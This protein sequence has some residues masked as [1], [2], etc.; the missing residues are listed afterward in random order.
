MKF[1]YQQPSHVFGG[2]NSFAGLKKTAFMC[3][4]EG[5]DSFWIMD[6]LVQIELA[7]RRNDP[8]LESYTATAALASVTSKIRLGVLCSC[9]YFRNPALVAKMGATIDQI[10]SGRFWLG[11]GAGWYGKE[12]RMYGFEFP[13]IR[14]RLQML[15]ESLQIIKGAWSNERTFSF[16]GKYYS[17]K[18]II[19]EPPPIQKP[20]P[21]ILV[22]GGGEKRTLKLVAKYADACNLFPKGGDLE[23]KLSV[24]R[25]HCRSVGR[26]YSSILKTKLSS[27]M[28]GSNEKDAQRKIA[29]YKPQSIS[30]DSYL[31]SALLGNS[32]EI[33]KEIED[34][35]RMGIEYLII[36]F[37]G[38][39]DPS[40][41]K[42]F[43]KEIMSS[44]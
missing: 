6:H 19:V 9:N 27:V 15:E 20:H 34:Y 21:P 3:E 11:L 26:D 44:F 16:Y 40:A 14:D 33:V 10:S 17:V 23:R 41:I 39:F 36:N 28:F 35:E 5:F 12:A 25:Q 31:S 4:Q 38:K 1:G 7:G 18:E 30:L 22:G 32:A 29:Q 13:S 2:V 43:S 24:L 42:L 37:R 8:I